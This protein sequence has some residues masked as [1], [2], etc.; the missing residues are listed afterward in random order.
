MDEVHYLISDASK[1]VDVEA[2]VLRYWEDEL[3]L[4]IPRNEMGHRYY[5]DLHIRLFKQVKNLKEKGYQLKA[6]KHALDEV[7]KK[8]SWDAQL[9][10]EILERDMNAALQEFKEEAAEGGD[11]PGSGE[12]FLYDLGREDGAVSADYESD[13][14]TGPGG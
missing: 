11:K 13:Y 1:K 9:T 8:D 6:I 3:G 12:R 14:R 5:T 10:D 4:E 2:H 7:L